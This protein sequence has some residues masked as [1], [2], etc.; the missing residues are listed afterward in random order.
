MVK[1]MVSN[2]IKMVDYIFGG[3]PIFL[4][5]STHLFWSGVAKNPFDVLNFFQRLERECHCW[6]IF[7][8]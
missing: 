3:F 1:I 7:Q 2:P 4:G 8:D 6:W 5:F